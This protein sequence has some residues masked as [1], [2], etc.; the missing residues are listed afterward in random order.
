MNYEVFERVNSRQTVEP[1][2]GKCYHR[3]MDLP[4]TRGDRISGVLPFL[5]DGEGREFGASIL[6]QEFEGS[7]KYI[8]SVYEFVK[9]DPIRKNSFPAQLVDGRVA[10][11]KLA[12][13]FF[14]YQTNYDELHEFCVMIDAAIDK[15]YE[16]DLLYNR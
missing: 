7:E 2:V 3:L 10:N 6:E 15:L 11:L 8:V 1:E 4:G 13:M 14:S 9:P 16:Q 5:T 12:R